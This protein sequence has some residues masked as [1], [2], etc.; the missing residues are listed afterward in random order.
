MKILHVSFENL[1]SL[2]G[3]WE[4]DFCHRDYVDGGL[5]VLTGPTGAGKSTVLDAISLAL[6]GRT[7]RLGAITAASNGIMSRHCGCCRAEVTFSS[8]D[9]IWRVFFAQH[10]ARHKADGALQQPRCEFVEVP[11][12][13]GE[14]VV[15]ATRKGEVLRLVEEKTG[16]DYQRFTRSTLLAQGRFDAFLHASEGEKSAILEEITGT[17]VYSE[18]SMQVHG[19]R[20][21]EQEK[22]AL[23]EAELGGV[24]LLDDELRTA[25]TAKLHHGE[26]AL[27]TTVTRLGQTGRALAWLQR[28][29]GLEAELATVTR[30]EQA[31]AADCAAFAADGERLAGGRR[32]ALLEAAFTGLE[33]VRLRLRQDEQ[34]RQRREAG[35]PQLQAGVARAAAELADAE[36]ES[37]AAVAAREKAIPLYSQVRLLDHNLENDRQWLCEQQRQ[38]T[39]A[40]VDGGALLVEQ[41]RLTARG[42]ALAGMVAER[43]RL[44]AESR[45]DATLPTRLAALEAQIAALAE[46]RLELAAHSR[47]ADRR[48]RSCTEKERQL[49]E[50]A[51]RSAEA[52]ATAARVRSERELLEKE[53]DQLLAGRSRSELRREEE[54]LERR[55]GLLRR[56]ADLEEERRRLKAG[57]PCPLCGARDHPFAVDSPELTDEERALAT[58]K[59]RRNRLEQLDHRERGLRSEEQRQSAAVAEL[60]RHRAVLGADLDAEKQRVRDQAARQAASQARVAAHEEALATALEPYGLSLRDDDLAALLGARSRRREELEARGVELE[61][62]AAALAGGQARLVTLLD[63]NRKRLA[64]CRSRV[65]DGIERVNGQWNRRRQLFGD[66]EVDAEEA[67]EVQRVTAAA[68]AEKTARTRLEALQTGLHR[69]SASLS[70]L[71]EQVIRNRRQCADR[72]ARFVELLAENSFGDEAAFTACRL[73]AEELATLAAAEQALAERRQGLA[74]RRKDRSARLEAELARRLSADVSAQGREL[75]SHTLQQLEQQ[76]AGLRTRC[77]GLRQQLQSD[78]EARSALAGL[79]ARVAAQKKELAHWDRLHGLVGSADGRKYR[80][81]AQG[82]TFELVVAHAG[83]QLSRM[84]DRY[85]LERDRSAPLQL[86]VRDNWQGGELRPTD[87]LSG[88]ESFLVSLALALG[89]S[90]MA[91]R[92]VQVESL[93]LDEGFGTLDEETLETALDALA[94]LQRNGRLIGIISHVGALKERIATRIEVVP[95]RGGRSRLSGPG[96]KG[97]EGC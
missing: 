41:R 51:K 63:E 4:I 25:L 32:A 37:A 12:D 90:Q 87:N 97:G 91:S 86:N 44:L 18:I 54:E 40:A 23:L 67:R 39:S 71:N 84:T 26:R 11:A 15:L 74:A 7:P 82:L 66:R 72:K 89:L 1:N 13:G 64:L 70:T 52:T 33:T 73:S 29:Q 38:L 14:G 30:E 5:F 76:E 57:D 69:E 28:L 17:A 16:M 24:R 65:A 79:K 93:F 45:R 3:S 59:K 6:F 61:R 27:Q 42:E 68:A 43:D 19:R 88:G 94:G 81:F 95:I 49:A 35:L 36:K 46:A 47:E 96:V 34:E 50:A 2:Y 20:R 48:D 53:R 92:R 80:N 78:A 58:L 75:L 60:D 31:L 8:L 21:D 55:V 9:G 62:Q 77:A 56:I 22:L 83:R 85:L 10:R